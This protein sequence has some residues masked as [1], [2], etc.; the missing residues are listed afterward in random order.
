[1]TPLEMLAIG[2]K[3]GVETWAAWAKTQGLTDEQFNIVYAQT[4]ADFLARDP[5]NLPN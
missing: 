2:L 4:Q 1:M 5:A 3:L